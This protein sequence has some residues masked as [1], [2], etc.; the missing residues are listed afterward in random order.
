MKTLILSTEDSATYEFV[1]GDTVRVVEYV[2]SQSSDSM[3]E[4][5]L[6]ADQ[7]FDHDKMAESEYQNWL[8]WVGNPIE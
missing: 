8:I 3:G 6:Y 7:L 2:K 4:N 5:D 1:S